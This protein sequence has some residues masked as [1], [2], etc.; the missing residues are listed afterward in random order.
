M[1]LPWTKYPGI[2]H[3]SIGW[4]CGYGED[5]LNLFWKWF[6][7]LSVELKSVYSADNPEAAGWEGFYQRIINSPWI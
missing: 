7:A 3:G 1:L 2:E 5:Y 6:S 4:R